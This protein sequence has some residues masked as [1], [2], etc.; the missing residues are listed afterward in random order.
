[1]LFIGI[2]IFLDICI[3]HL[4]RLTN[5][6]RSCSVIRV[7]LWTQNELWPEDFSKIF[8]KEKS[9]MQVTL[10]F[11]FGLMS[12]VSILLSSYLCIAW[13]DQAVSKKSISLIL[14][15]CTL[16][17]IIWIPIYYQMVPFKLDSKIFYRQA[18]RALKFY[19]WVGKNF[20]KLIQKFFPQWDI[21]EIH[22][23]EHRSNL[24]FEVQSL[25]ESRLLLKFRK[26][27]RTLVDD[28]LTPRA[29]IEA[30]E[31][32]S[33]VEQAINLVETSGCSRL[34]VYRDDLNKIVGILYAKDLLKL[35]DA[36]LSQSVPEHLIRPAMMVP[37]N[38]L[39]KEVFLRMQRSKI[40]LAIVADEFGRIQGLITLEDILEELFGEILDE[41]D[42]NEEDEVYILNNTTFLVDA[43][44]P[45]E[46]VEKLLQLEMEKEADYDSLSG[47][48]LHQAQKVPAQG[49]TI[50]FKGWS[51]QIKQRSPRA[52][53]KV[54]ISLNEKDTVND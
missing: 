38:Q 18:Q 26:F 22:E 19:Q 5:F 10:R 44:L 32:H 43:S 11:F 28:I 13:F 24:D 41:F 33:S 29:H 6:M 17:I 1:M 54:L 47:F 46:K 34:P 15:L 51:F 9:L 36:D 48:L 39:I 37:D 53:E 50:Y 25:D 7:R 20:V 14:F 16:F 4:S 52:I 31:I 3:F 12:F 42:F 40:H 21:N 45:I 27:E 30:L 8:L 35:I 49:E 2:I 23:L